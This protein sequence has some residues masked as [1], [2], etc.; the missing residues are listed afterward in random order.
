MNG[1][2]CF[3]ALEH[4]GTWCLTKALTISRF[5]LVAKLFCWEVISG[6]YCLLYLVAAERWSSKLQYQSRIYGLHSKCLVLNKM[7]ELSTIVKSLFFFYVFLSTAALIMSCFYVQS[8]EIFYRQL[9]AHCDS[10]L[11]V[12]VCTLSNSL[13]IFF[14]CCLPLAWIFLFSSTCLCLMHFFAW[15]NDIRDWCACLV[16]NVQEDLLRIIVFCVECLHRMALQHSFF[17]SFPCTSWKRLHICTFR[18]AFG[19]PCVCEHHKI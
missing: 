8:S 7:W 6:K 14:N 17:L 4:W 9:V 1:K 5:L 19:M 10:F 13:A 15:L 2:A 18:K 16:V 11:E 3:E 12:E